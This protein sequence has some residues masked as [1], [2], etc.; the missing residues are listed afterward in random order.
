MTALAV[1]L[2]APSVAFGGLVCP[3]QVE[4]DWLADRAEGLAA[5]EVA[6]AVGLSPYDSR[7]SMWARK[8]GILPPALENRA[9]RRGRVLEP[10]I[11]SEY[12]LET[13]RQLVDLGRNTLVRSA[14]H[15]FLSC[16][17]DRLIAPIDHRGVGVLEIKS[18]RNRDAWASG[19]VPE[20]YRIQVL[21]N[22]A[23]LELRWGVLCGYISG[24]DEIIPVEI[25]RNDEVLEALVEE[26]AEFHAMVVAGRAAIAR[27]EEPTTFPDPDTSE[28]TREALQ[29][30]Y[31]TE[32]AQDEVPVLDGEH[33]L[34][35]EERLVAA[36][37]AS[38]EAAK[39]YDEAKTAAMALVGERPEVR[40]PG[41]TRVTWKT[42]SKAAFTVAAKSARE[43]RVYAPKEKK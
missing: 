18:V 21:I 39:A 14:S 4:S 1:A 12:A 38:K 3:H 9:M 25:E 22:L 37:R 20:H 13:G 36:G 30:R 42:V 35:L 31:Q 15:P 19:S 26:A 33:A 28:A 17:P 10:F 23:V 32:I 29:A 2:A 6:A 11:A 27:G 24:T 16:T 40:F 8:V 43:F 41:G 7:Y 34:E 5:S